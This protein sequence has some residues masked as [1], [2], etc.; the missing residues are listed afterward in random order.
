[1]LAPR[2]LSGHERRLACSHPGE[3]LGSSGEVH[4]DA[5]PKIKKITIPGVSKYLGKWVRVPVF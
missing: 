4:D 2:A 3:S 5:R 1:M